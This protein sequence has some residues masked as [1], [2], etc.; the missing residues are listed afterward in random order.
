[1]AEK[2]KLEI[3]PVRR[4]NSSGIVQLSI[5]RKFWGLEMN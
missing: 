4:D 1:M 5:L 2:I 3:G